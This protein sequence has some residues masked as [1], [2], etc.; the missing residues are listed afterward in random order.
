MNIV[1]YLNSKIQFIRIKKKVRKCILYFVIDDI[2]WYYKILK[3]VRFID[4]KLIKKKEIL[5]LRIVITTEGTAGLLY[6]MGLKSGVFSHVFIDEAGQS[7][8]PETLL[9]LGI[10]YG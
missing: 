1:L 6:M 10:Y 5:K 8:E 3:Q 7:T 9:P 4:P 2:S